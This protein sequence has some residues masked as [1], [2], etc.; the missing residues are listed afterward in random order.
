M[1]PAA[2]CAGAAF[3]PCVSRARASPSRQ[4][5]SSSS[6]SPSLGR[7]GGYAGGRDRPIDPDRSRSSSSTPSRARATDRAMT[8]LYFS[9]PDDVIARV[10]ARSRA[11]SR[12]IDRSIAP[13]RGGRDPP[14]GWDPTRRSHRI[15]SHRD[16]SARTHPLRTGAAV[17]DGQR[18]RRARRDGGGRRGDLHADDGR[19]SHGERLHLRAIGGEL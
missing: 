17:D 3:T 13:A 11:S 4:S 19:R 1:Y 2:R 9:P 12:A 18:T 15:A 5:S 6:S 7:G 16:R 8:S 14:R 10:V